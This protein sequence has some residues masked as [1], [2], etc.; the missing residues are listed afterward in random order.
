MIIVTGGAGFIGSAFLRTLNE[1]GRYDLAVVDNLGK[2]EK[3][4]NLANKKIL[5]YYNKAEF[6][7]LIRNNRINYQVDALIHLG[8]CS[9]TIES[10]ADYMMRNN[11]QYSRVMCEWAL[12]KGIRFIYASSAATYGDGSFG[13]SDSEESSLSLKPLNIYALSKQLFDIWLIKTGNIQRATGIK[14]FNVYGPNE[15]HK[16]EMSSV[17]YKA[18]KQINQHGNISLFKSHN[19][20]FQDGEQKRDFVYVKDCCEILYWLLNNQNVHG[21]FNLGTGQARSFNDLA[22]AVF[23]ALGILENINYIDMPEAIR[24]KYQS[25]TQAEMK[26]LKNFGCDLKFHSLEDGVSDYVRNYLQKD[27]EVF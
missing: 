26:K 8:A 7:E 5:E 6:L 9:S 16:G 22:R 23:R 13:F 19:P 25:F 11:Y 14:F 17:I 20:V 18:F 1:H 4:K 27:F 12:S 3:W 15:Y 2:S 24:D 10:D 21:I